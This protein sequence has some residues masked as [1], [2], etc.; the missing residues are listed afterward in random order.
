[1]LGARTEGRDF[2]PCSQSCHPLKTIPR[3]W[4]GGEGR[5]TPCQSSPQSTLHHTKL[6]W[7]W[8]LGECLALSLIKQV[9]LPRCPT[10]HH[11]LKWEHCWW[12]TAPG[13]VMGNQ[14][15][16]WDRSSGVEELRDLYGLPWSWLVWFILLVRVRT[17]SVAWP[18]LELWGQCLHKSLL[19]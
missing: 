5:I 7:E 3:G 9:P 19:A 14:T 1:M 17:L 13:E 4:V 15:G 10:F 12:Q 11:I 8:G 18:A 6:K 2:S 16:G